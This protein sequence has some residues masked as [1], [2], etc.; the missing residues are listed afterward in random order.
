VLRKREHELKSIR[1]PAQRAL[2]SALREA[3]ESAG[4]TQK[5][6][7]KK[8]RRPQS[9]VSAY[10]SGD[11]KIDVL[12]FVRITRAVGMEPSELLRQLT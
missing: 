11:R 12:E 6:V 7:A 1:S 8:L 3:R 4:L 2:I 9:F 10:E 5:E